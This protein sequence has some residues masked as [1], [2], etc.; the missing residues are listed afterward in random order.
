MLVCAFPLAGLAWMGAAAAAQAPGLD[1]VEITGAIASLSLDGGFLEI[2][3]G[4]VNGDGHPDLVSVGDHG[5]P[6]INTQQHG[7]TAWLG[8]GQG[9]WTLFQTGDFGYGGCALGDA[10]GDGLMDIAYGVHHDYS[11][12][13]FGDQLIEVA[14]GDGSGAG[15]TPWDD[16]LATNGET[17]GMFGTDFGDIDADGDLDLGSTSF[18][19]CAGVHVYRN[20]A[21]GTWTQ[22][23]GFL[24]GNADS[25]FEF[26]DVDGDGRLDLVAGSASGA[27]WLGDGL[28]GFAPADGN[29]PAG[30]H[31]G[32]CAGDVD[33]DGRD[34]FA[35]VSGGTARVYSWGAGNVWTDRTANLALAGLSSVQE[36]AF[37]DMD[38]DGRAELLQF[39]S[40][41]FA[42]CSLLPTGSWRRVGGGSTAGAGT[43]AGELLRGGVD[44][45]H[46]GMPDLWLVQREPAG[47]FN[48]RNV[49]RVLAEASAPGELAIRALTPQNGRVWRGGQARFVH[50][51]SAVP[52]GM[53]L[54][55]VSLLLSTNDGAGPYTFLASAQ[56]NSGRAQVEVPAGVS[57]SACRI[58]YVLNTPGQGR[59]RATGPRFSILP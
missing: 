33:A 22:S 46:N 7:V 43:K 15:W 58:V 55:G 4:D 29:L 12:T 57:S 38:A 54:G 49:H 47:S 36:I 23:F 27:L 50:W 13:D 25:R 1:Y 39:A 30:H 53:P 5:S 45:D 20:H 10:D 8:D 19:C 21:D 42:I 11:A 56:P 51:A 59:R 17:Y 41:T 31:V 14:L 6:F 52:A 35:F 37:G 18:G 26:A 28:G 48:T 2:E 44:L 34:E 40:G 9:G 24:G 3:A 16:G 32:A